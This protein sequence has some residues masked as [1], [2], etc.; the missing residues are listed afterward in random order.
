MLDES[1]LQQRFKHICYLP[2][3]MPSLFA[4]CASPS[5]K[6]EKGRVEEGA[7]QQRGWYFAQSI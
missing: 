5:G 1:R 7:N 2:L 3:P 4:S 6:A